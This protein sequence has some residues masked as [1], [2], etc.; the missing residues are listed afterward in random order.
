VFGLTLPATTGASLSVKKSRRPA[1]AL[2]VEKRSSVFH[3]MSR[4]T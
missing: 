1:S 4:K 3:G 2:F